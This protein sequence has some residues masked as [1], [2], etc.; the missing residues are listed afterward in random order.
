MYAN[1]TQFPSGLVNFVSRTSFFR[2]PPPPPQ[3]KEL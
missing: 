2:A 1:L 3:K